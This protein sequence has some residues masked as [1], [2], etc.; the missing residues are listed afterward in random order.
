MKWIPNY[1]NNLKLGLLL[2]H[3]GI[4]YTIMSN[5]SVSTI[6]SDGA[7]HLLDTIP[8][9]FEVNTVIPYYIWTDIVVNIYC[10]GLINVHMEY[11]FNK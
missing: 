6:S 2:W 10:L 11:Y 3:R 9:P 4:M 7:I 1:D 5:G 8:V